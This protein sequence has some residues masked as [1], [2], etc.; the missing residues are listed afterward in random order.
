MSEPWHDTPSCPSIQSNGSACGCPLSTEDNHCGSLEQPLARC[1]GCG[2]THELSAKEWKRA[3]RADDAWLKHSEAGE[4][5]QGVS[6]FD[7]PERL[8]AVND[9][10]LARQQAEAPAVEQ[11]DLFGGAA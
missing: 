1:V 4:E 8:R 7:L 10:L 6:L 2:D 9:R 11:I 3:R 5:D